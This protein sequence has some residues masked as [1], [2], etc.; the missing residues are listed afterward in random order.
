MRHLCQNV[1]AEVPKV[2]GISNIEVTVGQPFIAVYYANYSGNASIEIRHLQLPPG[3]TFER[4]SED[5]DNYTLSWTPV[6]LTD[7]KIE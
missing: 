3:A 1:G 7:Y 6:N 5:A 4:I 2:V